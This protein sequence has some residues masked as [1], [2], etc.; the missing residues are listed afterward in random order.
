LKI[1]LEKVYSGSLIT[2]SIDVSSSLLLMSHHF[3]AQLRVLKRM[4]FELERENK[5][6]A[7]N[8]FV[9]HLQFYDY[10]CVMQKQIC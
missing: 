6:L 5:L 7:N 1:V 4:P 2:N 3:S 9:G 8:A 10:F